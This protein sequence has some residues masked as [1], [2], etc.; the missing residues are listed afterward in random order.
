[1]GRLFRE[2]A[3][4]GVLARLLAWALALRPGTVGSI[5]VEQELSGSLCGNTTRV[6]KDLCVL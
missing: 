1:M 3:T 6:K 5:A 2:E 4:R